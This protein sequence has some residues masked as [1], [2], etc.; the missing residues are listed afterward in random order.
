MTCCTYIY[1]YMGLYQNTRA[2]EFCEKSQALS[3]R[4]P[5]WRREPEVPAVGHPQKVVILRESDPQNGLIIQVT[6]PKFNSSPLK[7][8]QAPIGK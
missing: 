3:R 6:F 7:S 2:I 8:Y 4:E 1:I 5:K